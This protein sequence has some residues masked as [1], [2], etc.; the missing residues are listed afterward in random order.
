MSPAALETDNAADNRFD[1]ICRI[2]GEC[3]Y[4]IHDISRTE[5]DGNPP[6][7]RFNMPLE[8]GFFWAQRSTAGPSTATNPALF[9]IENSID[10]SVTYRIL[11]VRTFIRTKATLTD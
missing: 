8:L 6:L 1:K 4:G 3:C 9:S 2:V 10:F 5:V 11:L 7:P